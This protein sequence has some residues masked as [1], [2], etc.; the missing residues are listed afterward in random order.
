MLLAQADLNLFWAYMAEVSF[1]C[2]SAQ[3]EIQGKYVLH[4]KRFTWNVY[5]SRIFAELNIRQIRITDKFAGNHFSP[6]H[7]Y[8]SYWDYH[9]NNF[10]LI[11]DQVLWKG[12]WKTYYKPDKIQNEIILSD[13]YFSLLRQIDGVWWEITLSECIHS[14]ASCGWP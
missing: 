12:N 6:R 10:L 4:L 1:Q 11:V 5:S 3:K 7:F 14:L 2:D 9:K 13:W 8:F